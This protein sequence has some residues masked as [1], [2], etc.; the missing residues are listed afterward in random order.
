MRIIKAFLAIVCFSFILC[1]C[2]HEQVFPCSYVDKAMIDGFINRS[3]MDSKGNVIAE[4]FGFEID[5]YVTDLNGDGT[6]E[7]ICNCTYG[8]DGH[9]E[10]HIYVTHANAVLLSVLEP[11]AINAPDYKDIS[12]SCW[13]SYYDSV[14]GSFILIYP[15]NNGTTSTKTISNLQELSF[16]KTN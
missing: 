3:Y 9:K 7:L 1:S 11:D 15:N 8:A 14:S 16:R 5:D 10:V 2:S 6:N 4:S 13:S 12:D